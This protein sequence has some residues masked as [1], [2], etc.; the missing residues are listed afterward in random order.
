MFVKSIYINYYNNK[1]E[2][3][4]IDIGLLHVNSVQKSV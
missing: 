4:L 1:K 2:I 3:E